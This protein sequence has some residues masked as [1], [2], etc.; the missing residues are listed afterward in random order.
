MWSRTVPAVVFWQWVNQSFNALVNYTN[1]N[2]K[3]PVSTT[4]LGVAYVS[5]TTSA[6]VTALGLKVHPWFISTIALLCS[7]ISF[8]YRWCAFRFPHPVDHFLHRWSFL[9]FYYNL[10]YVFQAIH[11]Y[12]WLFVISLT[13]IFTFTWFHFL[14]GWLLIC[15]GG[16]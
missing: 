5:A 12:Y 2:A 8:L 4:Q 6:L 15:I 1:R 10:G 14:F 7:S 9:F 11:V 16:P 3:S 13:C